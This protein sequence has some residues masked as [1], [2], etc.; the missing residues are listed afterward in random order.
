MRYEDFWDWFDGMKL[1]IF[2]DIE[3]REVTL[4]NGWKLKVFKDLCC[5]NSAV[6]TF[7]IHK[8]YPYK[9]LDQHT[10]DIVYYFYISTP[11]PNE[12]YY[13]TIGYDSRW[14]SDDEFLPPVELTIEEAKKLH[15]LIKRAETENTL[16]TTVITYLLFAHFRCLN[17]LIDTKEFDEKTLFCP[18]WK[19]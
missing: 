14:A 8:T 17:E 2:S 7:Y 1:G 9:L 11:R 10:S 15:D 19:F 6:L 12:L 18:C 5:G 13:I 16:Y 3:D 4:Q